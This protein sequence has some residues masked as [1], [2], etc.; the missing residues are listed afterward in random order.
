MARQLAQEEERLGFQ[1]ARPIRISREGPAEVNR[2]TE[3]EE[4]QKWAIKS[5]RRVPQNLNAIEQVG[6][7]Q[8]VSPSHADVEAPIVRFYEGAFEWEHMNYFL[9]PYHWA[10]RATWRARR[11]ANAVDYCYRAFLRAGAARVI[12][13]VT[14][15]YEERVAWFLDRSNPAVSELDRILKPPPNTQPAS[16][17]AFRDLWIE[18]LTEHR[19]DM[20][21]GSGTLDVKSG[22]TEVN[23][24]AQANPDTQWR[25]KE[26]R[27][28]GREIFLD[29]QRYEISSVKD[30]STFELDRPYEGKSNVKA[31]YAAGTAPFGPPWTV[32]IPT[33]LVVLSENVTK[34]EDLG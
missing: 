13:P 22:F 33:S 14:P 5:L 24:N 4:L 3:R 15:G 34:I 21:R 11:E 2:A 30:E 31:T 20:A 28:L 7:Y 18:L 27:D 8:E 6:D 23:I 19:P 9:F 1:E 10:R 12:V 17:D 25:A 26:D 16:N 29:G 32:N